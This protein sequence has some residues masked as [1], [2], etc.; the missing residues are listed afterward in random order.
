MLGVISR[1]F[2]SSVAAPWIFYT[3]LS[4]QLK[5]QHLLQLPDVGGMLKKKMWRWTMRTIIGPFLH[6]NIVRIHSSI[7]EESLHQINKPILCCMS[8]SSQQTISRQVWAQRLSWYLL[9]AASNHPD[10]HSKKLRRELYL[11]YEVTCD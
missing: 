4:G 5:S 6:I 7:Q 1:L 11:A 10:L 3:L 2:F 8:L 9:F